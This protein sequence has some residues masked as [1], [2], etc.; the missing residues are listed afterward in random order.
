VLPI[1]CDYT[2]YEPEEAYRAIEIKFLRNGGSDDFPRVKP[3]KIL[4]TKEWEEIM[5]RLR[6]YFLNEFNVNIPSVEDYYFPLSD[7]SAGISS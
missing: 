3:L 2:G 6:A 5:L 4:D 1:I 7:F